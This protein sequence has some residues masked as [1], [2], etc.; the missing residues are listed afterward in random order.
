M[1]LRRDA[2]LRA[3]PA[4]GSCKPLICADSPSSCDLRQRRRLAGGLAQRRRAAVAGRR[5]RAISPIDELGDLVGDLG[6]LSVGLRLARRV[7]FLGVSVFLGVDPP[8]WSPSAALGLTGAFCS[9]G[10]LLAGIGATC[11][12]RRVGRSRSATS[13]CGCAVDRRRAPAIGRGDRLRRR[14]SASFG[15]SGSGVGCGLGHRLRAPCSPPAPASPCRSPPA[16]AWSCSV[17]PVGLASSAGLSVSTT[18]GVSVLTTLLVER[19]LPDV[20]D[21]GNRHEVDRDRLHH[22]G[23]QRLGRAQPHQRDDQEGGVGDDRGG[24]T[25]PHRPTSPGLA[26]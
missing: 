24:D 22:L 10:G 3:P 23:L 25:G 11:V 15:G 7:C 18:A 2:G 21:V 6:S 20:G 17:L 26:P 12:G 1:Q 8:A 4:I 13:C 9:C 5:R 19:A 16:S 14:A